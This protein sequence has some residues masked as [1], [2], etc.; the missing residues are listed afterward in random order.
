[1]IY[2]I[3]FLNHFFNIYRSMVSQSNPNLSTQPVSRTESF[4]LLNFNRYCLIL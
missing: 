1:M 3:N 2:R 4:L